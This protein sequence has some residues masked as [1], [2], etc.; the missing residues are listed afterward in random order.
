MKDQTFTN[1]RVCVAEDSFDSS[2]KILFQDTAFL[3]TKSGYLERFIV[4]A[5]EVDL[6]PNNISREEGLTLS[7]S[8]ETYFTTLEGRKNT[9]Q[10]RSSFSSNSSSH[11]QLKFC[12][13]RINVLPLLT[14]KYIF[15]RIN[16]SPFLADLFFSFLNSVQFDTAFQYLSFPLEFC[17]PSVSLLSNHHSS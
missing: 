6:H 5:I 17:F 14:R 12:I 7:R 9:D 2:H 4:E 10:F 11:T 15:F 1:R 16:L 13:I 3:S 8:W